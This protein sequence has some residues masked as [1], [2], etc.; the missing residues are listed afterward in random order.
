MRRSGTAVIVEGYMDVIA[1]HQYGF[2]NVVASMGTALTDR[3]AA[4]LQRFAERVVLAMD[5]DEA[6]SAANLRAIQVVA[7]RRSGP[8]AAPAQPRTQPLDIRVLA[9]PQGKDPDELIRSDADA[10]P[11]AVE[12]AQA[13]GRPPHR[14]RQRR[15]RPRA[16]ARPLAARRRGAAGR[17][18]RSPT[19]CCRRTTCSA[20][21]ASRA[22]AKTRCAASCRGAPRASGRR[23]AGRSGRRASDALIAA[24]AMRAPREEFCLALLYRV[25]E[26]AHRGEAL[27]G[28][29][30]FSLSENRELFRRWQAGEPVTEEDERALGALPGGTAN[31]YCR[32]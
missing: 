22:S 20:S 18:A 5:A 29:D 14:R 30:L 4:L 28:R 31:A 16:A 32:D 6:G 8:R 25:P 24:T 1:A 12:S 15:P 19:R 23:D 7:A 26:L 21:A 17:S 11:H 10:W 3:Q 27:L 13:G 2:R 9:L